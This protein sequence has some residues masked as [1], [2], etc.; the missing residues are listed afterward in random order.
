MMIAYL[1]ETR[2]EQSRGLHSARSLQ[3]ALARGAAH[4]A[5][6]LPEYQIG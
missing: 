6:T 2:R 5:L 3:A 4:L 1:A